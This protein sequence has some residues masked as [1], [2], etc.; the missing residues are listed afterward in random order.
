[1]SRKKSKPTTKPEKRPVVKTAEILLPVKQK[2]HYTT[3]LQPPFELIRFDKKT[4]IYIGICLILFLL[5]VTLKWHNSSIAWWNQVVNDGKDPD[6]GLLA[7][8]ALGIR[9]DE[10]AV[11]TTFA[12]SQ[13]H[14]QFP[15]ANEALGFGKI[16]LTFGL[17]SLHLLNILRPSLLGYYILDIERAFSWQWNFKIFPFL[18]VIFL[19]LMLFTR[20]NFM[21]SIFGS[22]WLFLSSAI[23]LWSINTDIFTYACLTVISF[24]YILFSVKPLTIILN[25]LVLFLSAYSFAMLLYPAYQVP[26]AY[27]LLA[28]SAGY[29]IWNK[30]ELLSRIKKHQLLKILTLVCSIGALLSMIILFYVE[31]Q[32]TIRVI[33]NTIYPGSRSETG[34]DFPFLK[35]FA[36]NYSRF[37]NVDNFPVQWENICEQSSYLMTFPLASIIIV[38]DF[39]K[40]KRINPLLASL[41][42]FQILL[43]IWMFAG[44]PSILANLTFFKTSPDY[45]AFFILGFSN[46]VA[47]ILFLAHHRHSIIRDNRYVKIIS[48]IVIL[49][50]SFLINYFLNIQANSFFSPV[51]VWIASILFASLNW[52]VIHFH[53]GRFFRVAFFVLCFLWF[54]PNIAINPLGKGLS[55]FFDNEVYRSVSAIHRNDPGAKWAVFGEHTVGNFLKAAGINCFNGV[56]FAPPMQELAILDPLMRSDSIYNRYAHIS[57]TSLIDGRDSVQFELKQ[58]ELYFVRMDPCSPK[59]DQ[60]GIKY[61]FFTYQPDPIE[62]QCMSF[63]QQTAQFFTYKRNG[64]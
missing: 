2:A 34:G 23:Q 7:G 42:A 14:N 21:L 13:Y 26:L 4:S 59:L 24:I 20:N 11:S 51:Q 9:S 1:M 15:E 5:F 43:Y 55:P 45:R 37:I 58:K 49:F 30:S 35:M 46:V 12:L 16:P 36:D 22:L 56:Q 62:I 28:L 31:T 18:I 32:E 27:F 3:P 63:V 33:A 40:S 17:P 57:F 54:I 29:L 41:V 19:L 47:T 39:I 50:L 8:K 64:V 6:R 10:W 52:L 61:I 60:L 25:G 48:F 38:A 44:L 53:H